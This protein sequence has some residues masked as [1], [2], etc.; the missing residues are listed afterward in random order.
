MKKP[1]AI[2][3][4]FL[5][6]PLTT[7]L[8]QG[9]VD[10][11]NFNNSLIYTNS[12]HNGPATGPI[13]GPAGTPNPFQPGAYT[14]ALFAAP[15][16]RTTV[17]A[18]LFGWDLVAINGVNTATPGLM[19]G[20]YLYNGTADDVLGWGAG[21]AANFLVVGWSSNIGDTWGAAVSWWNNGNPNAGPSGWFGISGIAEDVVVGG[22]PYPIPTIFGPTPTYEIQGFTL[23][24]Y[25]VPE[26][27]IFALAG[28][29]GLVLL[30]FRHRS[31]W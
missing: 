9:E 10:F 12:V 24:L 21:E 5:A 22:N 29:G 3:A 15:T 30:G 18:S 2:T 16:S 7:A 4:L 28:A 6:A 19:T 13:S 17:D 11:E 27:S 26:P 31:R 23:N 20:N 25:E 8:A 1:L 14:F